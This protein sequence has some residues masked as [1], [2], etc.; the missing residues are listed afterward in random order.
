MEPTFGV[1]I[2]D[3]SANKKSIDRIC[4]NIKNINYNKNKYT[5]VWSVS[6]EALQNKGM[7]ILD[8]VTVIQNMKINGYKVWLNIH[9]DISDVSSRDKECFTKGVQRS[10][11]LKTTD[12]TQIPSE[13]FNDINS[14]VN[15]RLE[16][17]VLF[18]NELRTLSIIPASVVQLKYLDYYD[19][20]LMVN[21]IRSEA[22]ESNLYLEINETQ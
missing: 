15:D 8:A 5:V 9:K 21:G 1:V 10:Y 17:I 22:Q 19:Y 20:D 13:V 18:E 14:S 2:Y 6:E 12:G 4:N 7:S 11:W 3:D 16:T